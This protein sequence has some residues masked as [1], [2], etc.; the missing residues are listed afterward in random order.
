MQK[1][2]LRIQPVIY[3][4][5]DEEESQDDAEDRFL[6]ILEAEGFD[7]ATYTAT[8]IERKPDDEV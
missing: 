5:M 1:Y 4:E 3:F 7:V 6:N 2:L 8:V